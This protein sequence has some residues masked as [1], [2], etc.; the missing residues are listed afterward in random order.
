MNNW[1][2][3][4][5][6]KRILVTGGTGSI[7]TELVKWLLQA[8]PKVVRIYS[9][10]E[11]KQFAMRKAFAQ[12]TNVRFLIGDV[13]DRE[14]LH[15]AFE[16]VDIVFHL[17]A[18]KHVESCEYN[19]F[20]AIKTNVFGT[21]NVIDCA[22][23]RGIEKVLFSS[24]DKAVNPTNSMGASKLMAERLITAAHYHRGPHKTVFC[25][26]RFGNVLNT[27]CSVI[28][29]FLD[30]LKTGLPL[31]ITDPEMTRF[32]VTMTEAVHLLLEAVCVA[33]GGEIFCRLMPVVRVIDLA[34]V[35]AEA[36]KI[37]VRYEIIG[38]KPGE[39]LCEEL[40]TEEESR[41]TY[42]A[43]DLFIVTPQLVTEL[44]L[45][46]GATP[47]APVALSSRDIQSIKPRAI[48]KLLKDEGIFLHEEIT[49]YLLQSQP[50]SQPQYQHQ[51][52]VW[53]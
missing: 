49:N 46:K 36:L 40:Y 42:K 11:S 43:K 8:S 10:D 38:P 6:G 27:S 1:S 13:R 7:G 23:E 34:S 30:R 22:L 5:S 29:V 41:R 12:Y 28:P 39:K 3:A 14:R 32:L 53:A 20:E 35:L 52:G 33:Q 45:P 50:E 37:P 48:F 24:T 9:R 21:Q 4:I 16:D 17:A 31:E 15:R 47:V 26:V 51:Q 2:N 44:Q 18:M 19:P 25:A